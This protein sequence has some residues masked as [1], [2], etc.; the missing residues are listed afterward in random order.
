M[1]WL[2][3][4]IVAGCGA[5]S[6][7][8]GKAAADAGGGDSDVDADTDTGT[9]T[10]RPPVFDAGGPDPDA[11][12]DCDDLPEEGEV[13]TVGCWTLRQLGA[14]AYTAGTSGLDVDSS[15]RAHVLYGAGGIDGS[16][17]AHALRH[18]TDA[19]GAWLRE[20]ITLVGSG[21]DLAVSPGD[22]IHALVSIDS[23]LFHGLAGPECWTLDP[24]PDWGDVSLDVDSTEAAHVATHV[25]DR[26]AGG[27]WLSHSTN[28]G[29]E[30]TAETV[31]D[32]GRDPTIRIDDV[33]VAH[34]LY[35]TGRSRALM[36]ATNATGAWTTEVVAT[37]LRDSPKLAVHPSGTVHVAYSA[38]E[39]LQYATN[40]SGS[41]RIEAITGAAWADADGVSIAVDPD[42]FVH[43]VH[44]WRT[45]PGAYDGP[46]EYRV[47]T[48]R[49][50]AWVEEFLG[51]F[52]SHG[53]NRS[54]IA[55]DSTG[56]PH[57]VYT[58]DLEGYSAQTA[59][60]Y[61]VRDC[62]DGE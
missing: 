8:A 46:S 30:W 19:S 11:G 54:R 23:E 48:N 36:Y 50:G 27:E 53:T 20:D 10:D 17:D 37:D 28:E 9:G 2:G 15:D 6:F 34:I 13:L 60:R 61:A 45:P 24:S 43:V 31:D 1:Q 41:W 44:G 5:R 51:D 32:P 40:A 29:G 55:V 49:T 16:K 18:A 42:G 7:E 52:A 47:T 3:V 62:P 12:V 35:R 21:L 58:Y 39:D 14:D 56:T 33:D 38:G 57:V 25:V 59:V 26:A 4:L 22:G